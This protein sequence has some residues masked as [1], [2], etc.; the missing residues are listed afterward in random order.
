MTRKSEFPQNRHFL[1]WNTMN[2]IKS[3]TYVSHFFLI[4]YD[5][6]TIL[7]SKM[8]SLFTLGLTADFL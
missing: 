4:E 7:V 6:T 8:W 1:D 3:S 2:H 5:R